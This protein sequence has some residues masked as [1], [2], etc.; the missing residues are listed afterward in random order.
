MGGAQLLAAITAGAS[1]LAVECDETRADFR[2]LTRCVDEKPHD[3]DEALAM[4]ERWTAAGE[5]KSVALIGNAADVFCPSSG[6]LG[7]MAS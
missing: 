2:L 4:I 1:C 3:L 5:A 6:I 7:Q